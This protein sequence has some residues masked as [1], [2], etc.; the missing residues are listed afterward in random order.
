MEIFYEYIRAAQFEKK[1][2]CRHHNFK[3]ICDIRGNAYSLNI[4]NEH[5]L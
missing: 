4:K 5:I 3:K 2:K 1:K